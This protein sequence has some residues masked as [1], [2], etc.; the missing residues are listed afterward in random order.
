[1]KIKLSLLKKDTIICIGIVNNIEKS[2]DMI[3]SLGFQ[4]KWLKSDQIQTTFE[5]MVWI[6]TGSEKT[7]QS[8]NS[9]YSLRAI[10]AQKNSTTRSNIFQLNFTSNQLSVCSFFNLSPD[11][12]SP[13]FIFEYTRC[14]KFF[15]N[16]KL[17][18]GHYVSVKLYTESQK[19]IKLSLKSN[20]LFQKIYPSYRENL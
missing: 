18:N 19:S 5:R 9:A 14:R 8:G 7:D 13:I 4:T 2:V 1:M 16:V 20:K 12:P 17:A 3:I 11:V 10:V 15:S 6:Q